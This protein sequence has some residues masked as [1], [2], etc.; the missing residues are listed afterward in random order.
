VRAWAAI[1]QTPIA[2]IN[3]DGIFHQIRENQRNQR[4]ISIKIVFV[5]FLVFY[6]FKSLVFLLFGAL[7]SGQ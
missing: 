5:V 4:Y 3:P 7:F 1:T 2:P 6:L